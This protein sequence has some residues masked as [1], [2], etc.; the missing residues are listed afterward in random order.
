MPDSPIVAGHPARK[1]LQELRHGPHTVE[2]LANSLRITSNAVR[3]QLNKLIGLKLVAASGS[4]PGISKPSVL[5]SITLQGQVQFSSLYLPVLAQFLRMAEEKCADDE[6]DALLK[7]TG[8]AIAATY[9]KPRGPMHERAHA[10]A[11][12]LSDFGG[13]A[14]VA[15]TNG[16]VTLRSRICPL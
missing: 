14:E 2:E 12:L 15:K 6:L 1:V 16:A 10:A 3:N 8:R 4:R 13:L 7:D 9:P 5:Y 11:R